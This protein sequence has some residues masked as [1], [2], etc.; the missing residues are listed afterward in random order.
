MSGVAV[1]RFYEML[2]NPKPFSPCTE[3]ADYDFKQM[4]REL[5]NSK[6]ARELENNNEVPTIPAED[7]AGCI[8]EV[9]P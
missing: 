5:E 1:Q 9:G 3:A 8:P 6:K 2:A 4:A 7:W